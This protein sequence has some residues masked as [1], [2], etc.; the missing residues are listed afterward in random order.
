MRSGLLVGAEINNEAARAI[1]G[2]YDEFGV[3]GVQCNALC[4]PFADDSFDFV[5]SSLFLHHLSDAEALT[6]MKEMSRVASRRFFIIDLHRHPA[7]YHLY[8]TFS[9]LFLQPLTQ[10]DGSLSILRS[11]RPEE[12]RSLAG[13]AGLD[14]FEVRRRAAFRLVLS[15]VKAGK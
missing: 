9:R 4:L 3:V 11:F 15:G 1:N 13:K 7:A 10:H 14:D 8:H 5:V 6:L 2:R 12:L